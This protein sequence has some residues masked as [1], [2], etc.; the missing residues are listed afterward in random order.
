MIRRPAILLPLALAGCAAPA[1]GPVEPAAR[2]ADVTPPTPPPAPADPLDAAPA[3]QTVYRLFVY[4]LSVP[5]GD[6]SGNAEFWKRLDEQA[7]D[8]ATVDLLNKNGVRVAV[9]PT[10][11]FGHLQAY[12]EDPDAKLVTINN[13][14][15]RTAELV[16][17]PDTPEQTVMYFNPAG[18]L[19][20]KTRPRAENV[21]KIGFRRTPRDE[22]SLSISVTPAI[23]S[24]RQK[25][26]YGTQD[27]AGEVEW[28]T[29][30]ALYDLNLKAD[31][32]VGQFL[33]IAPG[34]ESDLPSILGRQFFREES[35]PEL[36]ER[37]LVLVPQAFAYYPED[38]PPDQAAR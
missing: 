36:A 9:G 3:A 4:D 25:L 10:T 16:M 11:E 32:A 27:L 12:L 20:G 21:L 38:A 37:V 28:A 15:D 34:A 30:E 24:L 23:R 13:L 31:V 33:V 1:A 7:V 6:V 35:G 14:E 26:V 29:E 22:S 18:D 19:V 5:M 2:V 8:V 17:R